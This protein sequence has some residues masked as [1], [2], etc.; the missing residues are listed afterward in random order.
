M[1]RYLNMSN[2]NLGVLTNFDELCLPELLIGAVKIIKNSENT[3]ALV[4]LQMV[5]VVSLK[6]QDNEH[7]V[8]LSIVNVIPIP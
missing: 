2:G 8:S 6:Y 7:L 3:I 5:E 1:I 4:E